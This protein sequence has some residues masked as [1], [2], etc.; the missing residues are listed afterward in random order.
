MNLNT[1]NQFRHDLYQCFS[2][3]SDVLFNLAD[4]LLTETQ[5]HSAIELTLSPFFVRRWPSFYEGLQTGRLD[6]ARFEQTLVRYAPVPARGQRLV[7]AVDA[8]NIERPFS[9]TSPDRGWLYL[10]NLPQ[11]DKPVVAGWQFSTVVVVPPQASSHTYI[12]S[13]RRIPTAQTPAHF[14]SEQLHQLSA[15]FG[16]RPI[17][18]GD[19]YYPT[20]E[21][22]VGVSGDY[23][24][25]LRLKANRV[26]YRAVAPVVGKPGRGAPAKHGSRFQCNAPLTH[27]EPDQEWSG[28]DERGYKVQVREWGGLHLREAPEVSLS[29]ICV[30][31]YGASNKR[32]DPI[33]SWFVWAGQSELELAEVWPLYKRRYS[34]EHGYRFDKQDLLWGQPRLR[35]PAQFELWT[36]IVSMV[37]NQ[38]Q[39]AAGLPGVVLRPWENSQRQASPQQIRRGFGAI[40]EQLGTPARPCQKRGKGRGRAFGAKIEPALRYKVVKKSRKKAKSA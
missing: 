38:V 11:C 12:V 34:I 30:Q 18:L 6:Q 9:E 28:A 21:F 17:N 27:G 5:A 37:H 23:D 14:A 31:R 35:Y 25:L 13:N 2:Q 33:D 36:A 20:K 7:V 40:I 8:S 32:R 1:L 39:L 15:Y 26:F 10:H 3:A 19:R 16:E 29:I 4:A 24:L 22:L